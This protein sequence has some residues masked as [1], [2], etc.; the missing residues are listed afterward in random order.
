VVSSDAH[1]AA[2]CSACTNPRSITSDDPTKGYTEKGIHKGL[3][4][5]YQWAL[6]QSP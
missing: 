5:T 6:I 4:Q 2:L 1:C 3:S